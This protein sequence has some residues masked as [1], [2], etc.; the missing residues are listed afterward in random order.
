MNY[1]LLLLTA[2]SEYSSL[3]IIMFHS[4]TGADPGFSLGGGG[5][6]GLRKR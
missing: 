6:G 1:K 2:K 5:G 3:L 4:Y